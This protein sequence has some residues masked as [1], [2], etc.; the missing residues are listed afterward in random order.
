MGYT[1][2]IGIPIILGNISQMA[3]GLIDMA[4]VGSIDYVQLAASAL[5]NNVVAIPLIACIGLTTAL[6]PL[7]AIANGQNDFWSVSHYLYNG[8]ILCTIAGIMV[9]LG[10]NLSHN[11]LYHLGQDTEVAILAE[12]YLKI[13]G[14]SI[15]PMI[16]FLSL[17]QFCDALEY[18]KIAMTLSF[19]SLPINA[20]L[21]WV[22]IFGKLGFP[23]MELFGAGLGTL[24]TRIITAAILLWVVLNTTKFKQFIALRKSAWKFRWDAIKQLLTIGIPSSIQYGLESGAFAVTGIM[25]GWFGATQ[26]AAHQIALNIASFTFMMIMGVST[27]GSIRVSNAY[28]KKRIDHM[29]KIGFSTILLGGGFG[30]C[31]G[32]FFIAFHAYLP[33]LFN[34]QPEVVILAGQLLIFAAVFQISD[35]TQAVA[36]GLLR[37]IKDVQIPTIIVTIAYWIIGIPTGYF[38]GVNFGLKAKGMWIGL[39]VGLTVSSILLNLRFNQRTKK[40]KAKL[41]LRHE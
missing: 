23:R 25:I 17:K 35:S 8:V 2:K 38:L 15:I 5:V 26:Q 14:W 3:L 18:T 6:T 9:A 28:G 39:V 36:V 10:I 1:L 7:I 19:L 21:N 11:V 30:L 33:Y 13:V 41:D 29:R 37:G 24:I 34:Q 16:F 27:A 31:F 32:I 40:L 20:F 12:P 4:M 22:F